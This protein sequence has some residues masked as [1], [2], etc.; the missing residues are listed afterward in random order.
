MFSLQSIVRRHFRAGFRLASAVAYGVSLFIA[1]YVQPIAAKAYNDLCA[2]QG[3]TF[4]DG[5]SVQEL[6]FFAIA[7]AVLLLLARSN[8]LIVIN[9]IVS[10]ITVLGASTLLSSAG[11][12]PYECFTS[13]GTYEDNTSGLFGFGFWLVVVVFLSSIVLV[14]DLLIWAIRKAIAFRTAARSSPSASP[15]LIQRT[16]EDNRHRT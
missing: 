7:L 1:H 9:L 4:G 3:M 8:V 10:L 5:P 2:L 15:I 6:G 16:R 13:Q 12:T 11:N 14:I